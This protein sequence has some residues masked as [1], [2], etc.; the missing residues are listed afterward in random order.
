MVLAPE[1]KSLIKLRRQNK[2]KKSL[3]YK[4]KIESRSDLERTDLN[5]NKTGV[6]TGAYGINPINGEKLPIWIG[7][8][9]LASYGTGAIMAVP[10]HDDRD[11]EFAH[12]FNLPIKP[13]IEGGNVDEAAY[14]GDGQHINSGF[15]NGMD[16]K[17]AIKATIDWLE[18]HNAGKKKVNYRLRDWIFSRQRYW[19]NQFCYSLGRRRNHFSSRRWT[20]I[21]SASYSPTRTFRDWWKSTG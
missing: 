6:F 9:V 13:V 3:A 1:H 20:P 16:K 10:A 12:K 2:P 17:T 18:E 11:Y 7:D 19:A 15:L 4:K 8:Y 5:K 21:T 14:T